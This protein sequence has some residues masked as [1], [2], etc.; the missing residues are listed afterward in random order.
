MIA[1]LL[2]IPLRAVP[3]TAQKGTSL[4]HDLAESVALLRKTPALG[5]AIGMMSAG[6]FAVFL[7]DTLIAPTLFS[8]GASSTTFGFCLAAVGAGGVIGGVTVGRAT[9]AG[10]S[11]KMIALAAGPSGA[12]IM[13]VGMLQIADLRPPAAFLVA[14]FLLIGFLSARSVVPTRAI[15]QEYTPPGSMGRVAALNEAAST[16][17]LLVAP[18]AGAALAAGLS[19]GAAFVAGGMLMICVALIAARYAAQLS[20]K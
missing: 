8:L 9:G 20:D 16:L 3:A 11:F 19:Y 15:L 18:F 10:N 14:A 1:A 5:A 7:Y 4:R 13:C 6:F 12:T 17:A 2:L